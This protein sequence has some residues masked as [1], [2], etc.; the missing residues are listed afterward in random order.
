M[1]IDALVSQNIFTKGILNVLRVNSGR[2]YTTK[3]L[4]ED[5]H[6]FG[7]TQQLTKSVGLLVRQGFV[8]VKSRGCELCYQVV[9]TQ[10]K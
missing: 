2:S 7:S 1:E 8:K 6:I 4:A 3:D 5:Q 9:P 10:K